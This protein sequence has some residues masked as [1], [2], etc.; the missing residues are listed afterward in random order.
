MEN[1]I[2][3]KNYEYRYKDILSFYYYLLFTKKIL[4]LKDDG[5]IK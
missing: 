2:L 1:E 5:K 4:R 3:C